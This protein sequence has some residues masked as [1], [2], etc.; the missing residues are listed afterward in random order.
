[1]IIKTQTLVADIDLLDKLKSGSQTCWAVA[2]YVSLGDE[3]LSEGHSFGY[4]LSI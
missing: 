1:M 4:Q 2:V 3:V